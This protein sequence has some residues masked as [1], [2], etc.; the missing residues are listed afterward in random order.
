MTLEGE[1]GVG[2][3]AQRDATAAVVERG[4]ESE[5]LDHDSGGVGS[6]AAIAPGPDR[7]A[8]KH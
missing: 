1:E 8:G 2:A 6:G 5:A 3:R 4:R 7:G